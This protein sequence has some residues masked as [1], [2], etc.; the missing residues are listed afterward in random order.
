MKKKQVRQKPKKEPEASKRSGSKRKKNRSGTEAY[1]TIGRLAG[2][3]V[4]VSL[5]TV[6]VMMIASAFFDDVA[7]LSVPRAWISRVITPV[8]STFSKATDGVVSYLRTLKRRANLEYEY[9]QLLEMIEDLQNEAMLANHLQDQLTAYADLD[10]EISRNLVLNG[11]KADIIA[12]EADNYSYVFTINK[13][14]NHGIGKEMAVVFS[15]GLVGYTFDVD[16]D[17]AKVR[18]VV[19]SEASIPTLIESNRDQG[20]VEG[21]LSHDGTYACRMYYFDYTS[22]PRPGDRV[23]TSGVGVEFIKGIPVGYVRESTRQME[24][25]K[26]YIVI[27]PVVDFT[28]LE[29]VV[30]FRYRP[31]YAEEAPDSRTQAQSTFVPMPSVVPVPTFIGQPEPEITPGPDGLIPELTESATPEPAPSPTPAPT[32]DPNATTA[33]PN[34]EYNQKPIAVETLPPLVATIEPSQSPVPTPTFSVD[35]VTIEEDE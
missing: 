8:Q 15:G 20:W 12:R 2:I 34:Y 14:A 31:A 22:L 32:I 18:A 30:V 4:V 26:Q 11:V 5:L 10:D 25:S 24:D 7:F 1:Q 6:I 28:H 33:P 13:G 27:E 9:E 35:Q 29:H 17:T 21:T 19:D 3:A 16:D 23:V